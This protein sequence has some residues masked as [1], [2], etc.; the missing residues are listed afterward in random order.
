MLS[1]ED[2]AVRG[3]LLPETA[4]T[5]CALLGLGHELVELGFQALNIGHVQPHSRIGLGAADVR[6]VESVR[7]PAGLGSD[8]IDVSSGSSRPPA[9]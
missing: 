5:A 1:S 2:A 4:E 8:G 3:G 7:T 6:R 9:G